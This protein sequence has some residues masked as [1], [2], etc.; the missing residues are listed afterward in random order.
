MVEMIETASII[1]NLS[2]RSLVLMDEIGRGTSTYD[3][4][5]IA[6]SLVEYLHNHPQCRAKTLFATHYH[7]LNQ[8]TEDLPRVKNFNVAVKEVGNKILFMRQLKKEAV[9]TV[10]VSTWPSG[11]DAPAGGTAGRRD[12]APP[13]Q[14]KINDPAPDKLQYLPK[15]NFQ[16]NL[17]RGRPALD[18]ASSRCCKLRI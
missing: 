8:L 7:E 14:D 15:N 3:G 4:I 9:S 6:W 12:H 1:N 2:Q 18:E 13:E 10:L 5:S 11:R 16:L 17:F